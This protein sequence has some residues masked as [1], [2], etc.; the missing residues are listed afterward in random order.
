MGRFH[1][2][3]T[4]FDSDKYTAPMIVY[5]RDQNNSVDETKRVQD[6]MQKSYIE[7]LNTSDHRVIMKWA[8]FKDLT[9][10]MQKVLKNYTAPYLF[11]TEK[12]QI[13]DPYTHIYPGKKCGFK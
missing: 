12:Q 6:L 11:M 8:N 1:P 13:G 4:V 9:D 10:S 5:V 3:F 7:M 2:E